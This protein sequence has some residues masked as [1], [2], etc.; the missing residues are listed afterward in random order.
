MHGR[1]RARMSRLACAPCA[2]LRTKIQ[3]AFVFR[4]YT[5]EVNQRIQRKNSH[6]N[7]I[8]TFRPGSCIIQMPHIFRKSS[9]ICSRTELCAVHT[10]NTKEQT[11]A[12][13][14]RMCYLGHKVFIQLVL[15]KLLA[16]NVM[17]LALCNLY[18]VYTN[19]NA[20]SRFN[21]LEKLPTCKFVL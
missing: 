16:I 19:L 5:V 18:K 10:M 20:K 4:H 12:S 6:I 14:C 7:N 21:I 13:K 15:W 11:H 3:W 1:P 2:T 9:L 8:R 17:T